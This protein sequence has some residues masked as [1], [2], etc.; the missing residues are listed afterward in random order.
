MTLCYLLIYLLGAAINAQMLG[1]LSD[2]VTISSLPPEH[3]DGAMLGLVPFKAAVTDQRASYAMYVPSEAFS[4]VNGTNSQLPLVV[5]V[6]GTGRRAEQC[7]NSMQDFADSQGVAVLAPLFPYGIIDPNDADNYKN[8]LYRDIRYDEI[9]LGMLEEV[10]VRWE[11]IIDTHQIFM[12]GF[13]GGGQFTLRFLYLHPDRLK[14]ASI[15]APGTITS[16]NGTSWPIGVGDAE[17]VFGIKVD[18][19]RIKRVKLHLVVGELDTAIAGEGIRD[20]IGGQVGA[21]GRAEQLEGLKNDWEQLGIEARLDIVPGI[22]H[23]AI[24][25]LPAMKSFLKAVVPKTNTA[26]C[27]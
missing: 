18:I 13:S 25:A 14:A 3:R 9:I 7:R 4:A 17:E 11:G 22:E 15:G 21:M 16:L 24:G 26:S 19:E 12:M 6:H 27:E 1:N 23:D 2:F 20:V 10:K 5:N 8:I